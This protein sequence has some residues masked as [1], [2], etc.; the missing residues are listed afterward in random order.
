VVMLEP[1][2]VINVF[3]MGLKVTFRHRHRSLCWFQG[4]WVAKIESEVVIHP[5][6]VGYGYATSLQKLIRLYRH[7]ESDY[8]NWVFPTNVPPRVSGRRKSKGA[9]GGG[10]TGAGTEDVVSFDGST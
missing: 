8:K 10:H 9:G 4:N 5:F 7:K 1:V 3:G 6:V 2:R